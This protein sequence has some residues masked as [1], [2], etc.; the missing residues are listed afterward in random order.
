MSESFSS[1]EGRTIVL[2]LIKAIQDNAAYL[3][4]IDGAIG[5]G[6]HGINMNKGFSLAAERLGNRA[7]D[8]AEGFNLLGDTLVTDI[9]G[10]MGPLYG[11]F[12]QEMGGACRGEESITPQV[13]QTMLTAG[14]EAI[15][16]LGDAKVGDKTLIDTLVPAREAFAASV[17]AGDDFATALQKMAD[18]AEAGKESTRDLVARIGRASRL[19]ERSRGHLDPGATSC[20]ILLRALAEASRGL[21]GA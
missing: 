11:M 4:D 6:D 8:L 17:Q 16:S 15:Q 13:F 12:F 19:G 2:A 18:A 14:L 20:W 9:G 21:L 1:R 10:S 3:S 5:D 7:I